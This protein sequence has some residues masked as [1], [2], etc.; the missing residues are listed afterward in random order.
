MLSLVPSDVSKVLVR[1]DIVWLEDRVS[2]DNKNRQ[3]GF[4]HASL[5]SLIHI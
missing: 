3:K 4:C 1:L 5:L 2:I